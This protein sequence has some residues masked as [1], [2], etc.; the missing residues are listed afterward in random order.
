MIETEKFKASIATPPGNDHHQVDFIRVQ[1]SEAIQSE[2]ANPPLH[3]MSLEQPHMSV[4]GVGVHDAAGI[5][6]DDFFHLICHVD[7]NL[8]EKIE[9]GDYVDLDTL[10][11]KDRT[12]GSFWNSDTSSVTDGEKLEWV[13]NKNGTFLMPAKKQSRINCFRRWEQAFRIYATI[14][15]IRIHQEHVKFGNTYR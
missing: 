10:L 14:Y 8:K 3:N 13:R 6:D 15:C 4:G 11:N 7:Q 9:K 5:S 12:T 1:L 2:Q